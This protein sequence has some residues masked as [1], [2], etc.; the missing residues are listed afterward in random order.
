[1]QLEVNQQL[2][3]HVNLECLFMSFQSFT[4]PYVYSFLIWEGFEMK[5]TQATS[6]WTGTRTWGGGLKL[7]SAHLEILSGKWYYKNKNFL[8][9]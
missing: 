4:F 3:K 1:M 6:Y 7:L 9:K 5:T 2:V 8:H